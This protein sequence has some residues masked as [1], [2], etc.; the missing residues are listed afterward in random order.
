MSAVVERL[1]EL[2]SVLSEL[3]DKDTRLNEKPESFAA[4]DLEFTQASDEMSRLTARLD[5]LARERRN[6]EG[7]L[8]DQQEVLKKCQGQLMQVKNQ[9]QYAAAWKE[10]DNA[11][12]YAKELEENLLKH[13]SDSDETQSRLDERKEGF[14]ELK[15]RHDLAYEE[16]QHSLSDLRGEI[17]QV[18][19]RVS[20]I[21]KGVEAKVLNEFHRIFKQRQGMAVARVENHACGACRVRVRPQADQQL[22]RGELTFCEGCRRILYL[23]AVTS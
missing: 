10:I 14:D 15:E 7:E 2:Q 19:S 1:W 20:G 5:E 18:R 17:D 4:I 3:R 8:Q 16:W 6:A 11:R 13:M 9:Q 12:R 21:E 23:E 22:R